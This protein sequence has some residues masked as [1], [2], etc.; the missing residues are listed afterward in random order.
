MC[1]GACGGLRFSQMI[2]VIGDHVVG[3]IECFEMEMMPKGHYLLDVFFI[4]FTVCL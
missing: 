1:F 3:W 2:L 4:Y